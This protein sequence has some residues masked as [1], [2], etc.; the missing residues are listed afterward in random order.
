MHYKAKYLATH[1]IDIEIPFVYVECSD[2][3]KIA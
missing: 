3:D 2:S 1:D